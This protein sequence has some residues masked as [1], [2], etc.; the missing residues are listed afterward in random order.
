[1]T[2]V[3]KICSERWIAQAESAGRI[4]SSRCPEAKKTAGLIV[5]RSR[6]GSTHVGRTWSKVSRRNYLIANG[7]D[8]L[9]SSAAVL[10]ALRTRTPT[11]YSRVVAGVHT[12]WR[13]VVQAPTGTQPLPSFTSHSY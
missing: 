1:M 5:T 4:R 8:A 3:C 11:K 6:G 2:T 12:N 13:D 7:V 9:A 10:P